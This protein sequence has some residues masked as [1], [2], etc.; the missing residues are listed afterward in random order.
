MDDESH[1]IH[2]ALREADEIPRAAPTPTDTIPGY[3]I[4]GEIH[5]GAQGVVYRAVQSSTGQ[6]VAVKVMKEGPHAGDADRARFDREVQI[7]AQLRH[8][9][10][11]SILDTGSSAGSFFFV[12]DYIDGQPL[13]VTTSGP[14]RDI[15]GTMRLF[16]KI[17]SALHAAHVRGVI[18]RDLKPGNILVDAEGEPH[19]LDFGLAKIEDDE[20]S[21]ELR[22]MTGQFVGSIPWSSPEQADSP[23]L[24][25]VRSDVYALG[26]ILY[27][28]LTGQFPYDVTGNLRDVLDR[29]GRAEPTPPRTLEKRIDGELE[30]ILLT[31][32]S[33]DPDR[34]Y[35][36]AGELG[37]DVE[38]W[39]EGAPLSAKRDSTWYVL[40]KHFQRHR[41]AMGVA[42][43]LIVVVTAGFF[44]S[45]TFWREAERQRGIAEAQTVIAQEQRQLALDAQAQAEENFEK[46]E[47]L[48]DFFENLFGTAT[49]APVVAKLASGQSP[50]PAAPDAPLPRDLL[51][52][53][54]DGVTEPVP[55][56]QAT[57][58]QLLERASQNV[59]VELADVPEIEARARDII[60]RGFVKMG[61]HEAGAR[62]L[63]EALALNERFKGKRHPDTLRS[64]VNLGVSYAY[65]GDASEAEA[66][67]EP[68]VTHGQ[69]FFETD[70]GVFLTAQSALGQV[71]VTQGRLDEG[72]QILLQVKGGLERHMTDVDTVV[73][74]SLVDMAIE[75]VYWLSLA[76][77]PEAAAELAEQC[78][79]FTRQ[80]IGPNHFV[81]IETDRAARVATAHRKHAEHRRA[82]AAWV[83]ENEL[84]DM[85]EATREVQ[86]LVVNGAGSSTFFEVS[87]ADFE[88]DLDGPLD[89]DSPEKASLALLDLDR[90]RARLGPENPR[91]LTLQ[92]RI[93][94][95]MR[96][97]PELRA[98]ATDL[99]REA[100]DL[101][102]AIKG[103]GDL[104]TLLN[105]QTLG[106]LLHLGGEA[107]EADALLVDLADRARASVPTA[108]GQRYLF[109]YT[110][111]VALREADR[112]ERAQ[113]V[114]VEGCEGL[115]EA[116]GPEHPMTRRALTDLVVLSRDLDR[117]E[118]EA[119]AREQLASH[120]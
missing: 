84:A 40:G 75:P 29:I 17:C 27:Q 3:R 108:G 26:V 36:T 19:I 63:R 104:D 5:R 96:H 20:S 98:E 70:T 105:Q 10:I 97:L 79:V 56:E 91:L 14:E 100:L 13:D 67:L 86:R 57:L 83:Y 80:T 51:P 49:P 2:A 85:A 15:R 103:D 109:F 95:E 47:R 21:I 12:M 50:F 64:Q 88:L 77:D 44:T 92:G 71:R 116:L 99:A 53:L 34:R 7:L 31:C 76:G 110:H 82:R 59:D 94:W 38:A 52:T 9:N 73:D 22:T 18:H 117:P 120:G 39:L 90:M 46:S 102:R 107:G 115:V 62:E 43:A 93:A 41:V 8:R 60:G 35:Q 11:V 55:P 4:E 68:V 61:R 74:L 6:D 24:V 1:L 32:L 37:R 69:G 119:W 33:K 58:A 45:L 78:R 16:A 87:G 111:S 72:R 23:S 114:L 118:R 48:N 30:T 113:E 42:A 89:L 28:M 101:T 81:T 66:L 65:A 112:P 25:D 54:P 106:V